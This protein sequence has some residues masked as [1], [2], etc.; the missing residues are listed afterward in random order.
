MKGNKAPRA[1]RDQTV[2]AV[3]NNTTTSTLTNVS[4]PA[5]ATTGVAF[6]APELFQALHTQY[7]AVIS[8]DPLHIDQAL[9]SQEDIYVI[10]TGT[11]APPLEYS[12]FINQIPATFM[13]D[14]GACTCYVGSSFVQDHGLP[15]TRLENPISISMADGNTYKCD[16]QLKAMTIRLGTH[17]STT[18]DLL[19]V[20][21]GSKFDI[22]LG[23]SW[24]TQA[25]PQINWV[26]GEMQLKLPADGVS[27]L[28]PSKYS[29]S[30]VDVNHLAKTQSLPD[31]PSGS[32]QPAITDSPSESH[33][34]RASVSKDTNLQP[35][36]VNIE[37]IAVLQ[38]PRATDHCHAMKLHCS[39]LNECALINN[40]SFDD[41][42]IR[43]DPRSGPA[44]KLLSFE[45]L[46]AAEVV[47][48]Y[49]A[50]E[51]IYVTTLHQVQ[52]T[53][54][55]QPSIVEFNPEF[56]VEVEA[57]LTDF[58]DVFPEDLPNE[59]P[60]DR[61]V[62]NH[63][64]I[65]EP[66][67]E[68][69]NRQNYRLG[70][71]EEAEAKRQIAE[72]LEKGL[73]RPSTS[74]YGSPILFVPKKEPGK[75]RMCIDYRPLNK[76]TI[77]NSAPLPRIDDMLDRLRNAKYFSSLDLRSGY[78]QIRVIEEDIPK[79]AFRTHLGLYEFTVL[80]F[81]L[82]NAPATFQS[83][84]NDIFRPYIGEFVLIYLDDIMI[85]SSTPEEHVL[86]V[87]TVLQ[88][89]R[90]HKLYCAP[91]KCHLFVTKVLWLGHVVSHNQI[92]M[93]PSKIEAVSTWPEPKNLAQLLSFLGFT[94]YYRRFIKDYA[95][96]AMPLT[97]LLR[98]GTPWHWE[99][100][101]S[102][103]FNQLKE[104]MTSTPVLATP[105][106][107][108][109]FVIH[110]DAS[111]GAMGGVLMQDQGKG[112]QVIAYFSKKLNDAQS[113]YPVHEQELLALVTALTLWRSYLLGAPRSVA[114]TDHKALT[115]FQ[116]Q[117]SLTPRQA[118]WQALLQEFNI[119]IDYLPGKSNVVAD[120]LSRRPSPQAIN[121]V[122]VTGTVLP[123]PPTNTDNLN[124]DNPVSWIDQVK[125][126][127][128]ADPE[129]QHLM[130]RIADSARHPTPWK[131]VDGLILHEVDHHRRLFVPHNFRQDILYEHHD[132]PLAG[133]LGRDKTF[134]AVS[135]YF[136]WPSLSKDVNDYV[137]TCP[138]CTYNK[139]STQKTPG[140]MFS[141]AVPQ[142]KFQVVSMD[143]VTHLGTTPRGVD[144]VLVIID[145]LTKVVTL[146][147]T[148][149]HVTGPGVAEIYYKNIV[150][151][152]GVPEVLISDRDSRFT[153]DFSRTFHRLLGTKQ[154][155]S[156]AYHPQTDGQSERTIRTITDSLRCY[157][158]T[159][160]DWDTKLP[161]IEFAYNNS[162][163]AS[164][165]FSPFYLLYGQHP[166]TPATMA[167]AQA[168]NPA[169]QDCL[170]QNLTD[171]ELA[172]SRLIAAQQRQTKYFN[173]RHRPQI[174]NVGDQ[175]L[176]ST[177]NLPLKD[178]VR[179]LAPKW[180]G[181]WL[182][183][184][185]ISNSAYRLFL[186]QYLSRVH[187]VFHVSLLKP[188]NPDQRLAPRTQLPL[189]PTIL[190]AW[191]PYP[192]YFLDRRVTVDKGIQY[193]VKWSGLPSFEATWETTAS[194]QA[195]G[196]PRV[197]QLMDLMESQA[198]NIPAPPSNGTGD[199]VQQSRAEQPSRQPVSITQVPPPVIITQNKMPE[200]KETSNTPTP[201]V[202]EST[203]HMILPA[204]PRKK[205]PR[206][207]PTPPSQPTESPTYTTRSGRQIT[208]PHSWEFWE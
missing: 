189:D 28:I 22:L 197:Q 42:Q 3:T 33:G 18:I 96:I 139:S 195:L 151:R 196:I 24:L 126:A 167:T 157:S 146:L 35:D 207:Q 182:I 88:L 144:S 32:K 21:L 68:P 106:P 147:P 141:H 191:T 143:L 192:E 40:E 62:H 127:Y 160:D 67:H 165:G 103:A 45:L 57:I 107:D 82:C 140:L 206:S 59:M 118:R 74:P 79:T 114:H 43:D 109:P 93:D 8:Q 29:P 63:R 52:E 204:V 110:T 183:T 133:H 81:G 78:H 16:L 186:P 130:Q 150:I 9:A 175:V 101:Q 168:I 131:L 105:S 94:G 174:F 132:S 152:Y 11:A 44:S 200:V 129:S 181:P 86:H 76:I 70:Y 166:A 54:N 90:E 97:Q 98:K 136:Y 36:E 201:A 47:D 170:R 15:T 190:Q 128:A 108:Y 156:T 159:G 194:L 72:L 203:D 49:N 14:S 23:R 38:R 185:K 145:K 193:L 153:S 69:P 161:A 115:F 116:T 27:L 13:V 84:M 177:V 1:Q 202:Q 120:A 65:L 135:R 205:R 53:E 75:L 26:T 83:L 111:G 39:M 64:I 172:R 80:P 7:I 91:F 176:L 19:V 4:E 46:S 60:P 179:K 92:E 187:P 41:L 5:W 85:Y 17:Y 6:S 30:Q 208:R 149:I 25:K 61:G 99:S 178:T 163:N 113:R 58:S 122:S 37:G 51:V 171:I 137:S 184:Q 138:A 2:A 148:T 119:T 31:P 112:L 124:S 154:N 121:A 20:P 104:A 34:V 50:G 89:L 56:K 102:E 173:Q 155:L 71:A 10:D 199:A 142:R 169:A 77:K 66:G 134:A 87:R 48:L 164:T 188:Y 117:P 125:S 198:A 95:K 12:G 123:D 55:A 73:I 180:C 100:Q 158:N 162:V